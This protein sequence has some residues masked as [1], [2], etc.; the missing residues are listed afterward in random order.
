MACVYN[1]TKKLTRHQFLDKY[2][3]LNTW[4]VQNLH[5]IFKRL[6]YHVQKPH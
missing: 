4:A 6:F 3:S 5:I 1:T 2:H